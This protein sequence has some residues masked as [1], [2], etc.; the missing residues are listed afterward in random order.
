MASLCQHVKNVICKC[1]F[2]FK[3]QKKQISFNLFAKY[4]MDSALLIARLSA[5]FSPGNSVQKVDAEWLLDNTPTAEVA[6][7]LLMHESPEIIFYSATVLIT[8]IADTNSCGNI[9]ELILSI[10]KNR[11][12]LPPFAKTKLITL[13]AVHSLINLNNCSIINICL[14]MEHRLALNFLAILPQEAQR[15]TLLK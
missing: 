11:P 6:Q 10:L 15:H 7:S 3:K 4:S 13:L 9:D 8:H 2:Y 5:T 1:R 14:R 12:T